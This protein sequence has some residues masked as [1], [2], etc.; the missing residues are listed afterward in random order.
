MLAIIR[1]RNDDSGEISANLHIFLQNFYTSNHL[2]FRA[3]LRLGL[4]LQTP[5]YNRIKHMPC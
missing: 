1:A 3:G 2:D 5:R 4:Q